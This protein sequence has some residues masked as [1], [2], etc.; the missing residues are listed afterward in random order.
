MY[1]VLEVA[2]EESELGDAELEVDSELELLADDEED[3]LEDGSLELVDGGFELVDGFLIAG[4][5]PASSCL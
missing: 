3:E 5:S 2:D 1:A 4:S